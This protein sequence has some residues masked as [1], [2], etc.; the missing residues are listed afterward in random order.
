MKL[1]EIQS[2]AYQIRLLGIH[3]ALERR[4]AQAVADSMHPL[5]FIGLLLGDE[6]RHRDEAR[7]RRLTSRAKFRIQC[8]LEEWDVTYDRGLCKA[9]IKDLA[10]LNFYHDRENLLIYGKTGEGKTHLANA[11]GRRLCAKGVSTKFYSTN[12]LFEEIAADRA[13][14]GYLNFLKRINKVGV[15]ILD[16]FGLRQYS[17]DEANT[18]VDIIEDRYRKGS[19]IIT[20]QVDAKGWLRLFEDPVIGEAIV[21]RLTKPSVSIKLKGG[22][23]RSR[24]K[25]N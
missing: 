3:E 10:G 14:G 22:S 8:E 1:E 5:D 24:L 16:D 18:L 23:Y 6:I 7:T 2:M 11:V 13:A 4:S 15:L 25:K 17:H 12:L 9:K 19:I 20:S 21:D